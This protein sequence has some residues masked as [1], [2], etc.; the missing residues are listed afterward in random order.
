MCLSEDPIRGLMLFS[1]IYFS[2]IVY[3]LFLLFPERLQCSMDSTCQ[4]IYHYPTQLVLISFIIRLRAS[5]VVVTK[6][7]LILHSSLNRLGLSPI[8]SIELDIQY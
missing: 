1:P 6:V 5:K 8:H 3:Y 4:P 2:S 7:N